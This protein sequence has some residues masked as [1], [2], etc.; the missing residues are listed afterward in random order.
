MFIEYYYEEF[1]NFCLLLI[2]WVLILI[3]RNV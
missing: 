3:Y 2:K 1:Q